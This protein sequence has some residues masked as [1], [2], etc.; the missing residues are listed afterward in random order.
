MGDAAVDAG[1]RFIVE[2]AGGVGRHGVVGRAVAT[3]VVSHSLIG[4]DG[5]A[6][7]AT[8]GQEVAG[9]VGAE[10]DVLAVH[11]AAEAGVVRRA[12]L[13]AFEID[14]AVACLVAVEVV[15]AVEDDVDLVLHE[16]IMD[17]HVPAGALGGKA[18]AAVDV[19]ATPL[20]F[21]AHFDA[22]T[23]GELR[24]GHV[25]DDGLGAAA[26]DVV[27]EDELVSSAAVLQRVT[28]PVILRFAEAPVPRVV[29]GVWIGHRVPEGIEHDEER[30]A[31]L[32]GVVVLQQAECPAGVVLRR[33][34]AGVEGV[35]RGRWVEGFASL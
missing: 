24:G 13:R 3:D 23:R 34:I 1:G 9:G 32:E 10:I 21:V 6:D 28:Q 5:D 33:G 16:Q 20:V 11:G 25:V 19:V 7:V 35:G 2:D 18:G 26:D 12:G 29:G 31:P 4:A 30:L 8:V 27:H 17:G 15:V 14:D 22:A